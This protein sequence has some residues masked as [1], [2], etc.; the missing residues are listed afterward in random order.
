MKGGVHDGETAES[1]HHAAASKVGVN[2]LHITILALPGPDHE[3]LT[4]RL[5]GRNVRLTEASPA[6]GVHG[7]IRGRCRTTNYFHPVA[8]LG[9]EK[10][11]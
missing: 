10:V 7:R 8:W 5:N 2:D 9:R 3:K 11:A 4:C 6:G 1:G